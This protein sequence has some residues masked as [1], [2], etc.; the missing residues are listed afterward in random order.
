MGHS[1]ALRQS[2]ITDSLVL[3]LDTLP[4]VDHHGAA[5]WRMAGLHSAQKGQDWG[6]ILRHPMVRPG[7]KLE[8]AHLPLLTGAILLEHCTRKMN[9]MLR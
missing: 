6:G 7:H 1:A 2:Q 3:M 5:V 8:L 4:A 9:E